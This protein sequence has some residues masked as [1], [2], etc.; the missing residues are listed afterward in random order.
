MRG[1]RELWLVDMF[2]EG[3]FLLD[4]SLGCVVE[5][6]LLGYETEQE[7]GA[8]DFP[9]GGGECV[10]AGEGVTLG[11]PRHVVGEVK[12]TGACGERGSRE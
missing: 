9:K 8:D 5:D 3:E 2:E 6:V 7:D 1:G 11:S 10:S 12:R 4:G